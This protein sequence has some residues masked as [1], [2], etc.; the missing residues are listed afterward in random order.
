MIDRKFI[1]RSETAD[2]WTLSEAALLV[3]A[4][5]A[6]DLLLE[7]E[8]DD[9]GARKVIAVQKVR[10]NGMV[11]VMRTVEEMSWLREFNRLTK[12]TEGWGSTAT[13]KPNYYRVLV[14]LVPVETT[15]DL[16]SY[17]AVE[18]ASDLPHNSIATMEWAKKPEKRKKDQ[19]VTHVLVAFNTRESA[20]QVI[21]KGMTIGG[22]WVYGRQDQRD[23]LRCMKC[24]QFGH[25]AK[26]CHSANDVCGRCA[27]QHPT[28]TCKAQEHSFYCAVCK[29]AGH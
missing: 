27:D 16:W 22:K 26:E 18:E 17:E 15:L 8:G 5:H 14:E 19:K 28:Q 3:K 20:N 10:G 1:I 2:D 6:L 24:Q 4:N 9:K 23:P 25:I 29:L 21:T 7:V 12:F 11:C 13:A